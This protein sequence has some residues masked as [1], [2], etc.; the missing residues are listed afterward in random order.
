[1]VIFAFVVAPGANW[2]VIPGAENRRAAGS[3][4]STPAAVASNAVPR[5]PPAGKSESIRAVGSSAETARAS[6]HRLRR[7]RA[8][9]DVPGTVARAPVIKERGRRRRGLFRSRGAEHPKPAVVALG[10]GGMNG[11]DDVRGCFLQNNPDWQAVP[12]VVLARPRSQSA[13]G[14]K[15]AARGEAGRSVWRT[16]PLMGFRGAELPAGGYFRG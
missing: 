1:M 12:S 14:G 5:L 7:G 8:S 6:Q 10:L 13:C 9:S 2:A 15:A 3:S 11:D 16:A 4:R